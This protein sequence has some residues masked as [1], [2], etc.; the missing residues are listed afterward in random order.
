MDT[1]KYKGLEIIQYLQNET[2]AANYRVPAMVHTGMEYLSP[3][4]FL[5]VLCPVLFAL[6]GLHH[7]H[8]HLHQSLGFTAFWAAIVAL[9]LNLVKQWLLREDRPYW[10]AESGVHVGQGPLVSPLQ[11][12]VTCLTTPSAPIRVLLL[13]SVGT[14]LAAAL[15]TNI[16]MFAKRFSVVGLAAVW[17]GFVLKLAAL[18]LA[19]SYFSQ[20]FPHQALVSALFGVTVGIFALTSDAAKPETFRKI[21]I[22]NLIIFG[23]GV[24]AMYQGEG[25]TMGNSYH[26]LAFLW[27]RER[28]WLQ[29]DPAPLLD[30]F[31]WTG[32]ALGASVAATSKHYRNTR[33]QLFTLKM[34]LVLV[35]LNVLASQFLLL[36][37]DAAIQFISSHMAVV[38]PAYALTAF[39]T[40]FTNIAL[41]PYF[42]QECAKIKGNSN[43]E[44]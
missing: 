41:M 8:F 4:T 28:K 31:Q 23:I 16:R 12:P 32:Y 39:L 19:E 24:A 43:K 44:Q 20:H 11:F 22:R 33:K 7:R 42:V 25:L 37:P 9:R 15:S 30:L 38:Y 13:G 29:A 26:K 36:L 6:Q 17:G 34:A 5:T 27:C 35:V 40:C 14:V 10:W 3:H 1:I 2:D 18:V 21:A